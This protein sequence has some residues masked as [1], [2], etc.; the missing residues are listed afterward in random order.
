MRKAIDLLLCFLLFL[1][2]AAPDYSNYRERWVTPPL[3]EQPLLSHR[4]YRSAAMGV[5]VGYN[6]YLPPGYEAAENASRRYPV[7]YWLHGLNQSESTDQF[8][9]AIVDGAI[10]A[11]RVP[12]LIVVYVS[13]GSRAFYSDSADGR[14]LSET[15]IIKELIPHVEKTYRAIGSREGRAIQGMSMGGFGAL[16]LAAKYP[17]MFSSVVAFAPSLRTPENLKVTHPDVV[18]R[19]FGGDAGRFRTEHPLS[20]FKENVGR[21][22]GR[23]PVAFFIGEKDPLLEGDRR[24]HV[25]LD[26]LKYEHAYEEFPG[27]DHNL[28]KLAGEVKER[29]LVFAAKYFATVAK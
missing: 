9:P 5:E 3:K 13:G 6:L 24:L 29:G 12:A 23:L 8:P 27:I 16:K 10:R 17:E 22:R 20:L 26:E 11:G 15:T 7:I 28:I 4:S 25:M 18:D 21:L 14:I 19:M 1:A 2:A